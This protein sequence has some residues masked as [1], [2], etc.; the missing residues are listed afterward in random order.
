MGV[1]SII[2]PIY[3]SV[4]FEQTTKTAL[5][6][7][8]FDLKYSR[9][10]NPTVRELEKS[11][12]LIEGGKDALVFN[13]GMAAIGTL[14]LAL[15][16]SGDEVVLPMEGY[17]TSIQLAESLSKFGVKVKLAYPSADSIIDI[18]D[19]RTKLVFLETMT[20][21]TL[22]VIDVPEVIKRAKEIGAIVVVD[23]TFSPLIFKPLRYGA[24]G[25]V[26]S[27]T[28]YIAG[29]NDVL[30]GA[31]VFGTPN[32]EE[33][34]D[35]RRRIG[36][37]VQAMDAYLIQRGL[38][39][40]ELRFELQ[41]K[42]A[43]A[44]AEFLS[45]HPKVKAVYYPGLSGSPY[46]TLAKKLFEKPLFG[47]VVSFDLGSEGNVLRFLSSLKVIF[48]SPSLGGTESIA[49]YPAKSAAKTIPEDRRKVLNITPGL[50]R[51]SVG[52]ESPDILIE[53]IDRALGVVR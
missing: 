49:S 10:E 2:P 48:P 25:V 23:N 21:P 6:D 3:L 32:I 15:L 20:N 9:E 12:A 14:Y 34:W 11:I 27:L 38:K 5:S 8:G 45:E 47:G 43:Q 26:H 28:K 51:L 44:I 22:K 17:G 50:I 52:L 19:E 41:S 1:R 35:W 37:I 24:D 40:L 7:R 18:I 53:D 4:A 46:H 39:T 31:V 33:F 29:H 42:N 16:S 36:T 13:S 30:G